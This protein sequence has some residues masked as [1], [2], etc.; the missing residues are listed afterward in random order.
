MKNCS[1]AVKF[2]QTG[3][4]G[5]VSFGFVFFWNLAGLV[6]NFVFRA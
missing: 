5:L 1:V 4:K 6:R 2:F 3:T